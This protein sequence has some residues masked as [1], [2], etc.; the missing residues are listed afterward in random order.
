ML[1]PNLETPIDKT[2]GVTLQSFGYILI[3]NY[4]L[5]NYVDNLHTCHVI[6]YIY[7]LFK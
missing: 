5:C 2:L 6:A 3:R 4:P 7:I 1:D